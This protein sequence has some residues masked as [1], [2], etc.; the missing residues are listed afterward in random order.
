MLGCEGCAQQGQ[1]AS[2]QTAVNGAA[3]GV[4]RCQCQGAAIAGVGAFGRWRDGVLEYGWWAWMGGASSVFMLAA[5]WR[6]QG[7]AP[8]M[9]ARSR[10]VRGHAPGWRLHPHQALFEVTIV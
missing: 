2:A 9:T 1:R 7:S 8:G 3:C 6:H 10:L 5:G 4:L